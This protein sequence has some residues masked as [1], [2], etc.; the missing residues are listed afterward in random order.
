[1]YKLR[2]GADYDKQASF[3]GDNKQKQEDLHNRQDLEGSNLIEDLENKSA[4]AEID[5][6]EEGEEKKLAQMELN[7]QKK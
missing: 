2:T 5:A 7:H 4:Q 3:S 1:M 6:M